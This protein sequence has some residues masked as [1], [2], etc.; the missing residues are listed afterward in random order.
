MS[1]K[2]KLKKIL[3]LDTVQN[4][5][6]K[7]ALRGIAHAL[8]EDDGPTRRLRDRAEPALATRDVGAAGRIASGGARRARRG[9]AGVVGGVAVAGLAE[10]LLEKGDRKS[11]V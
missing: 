5:S 1:L 2:K 10:A 6:Q 8:L 3:N 11:V 7:Q 9:G 4:T